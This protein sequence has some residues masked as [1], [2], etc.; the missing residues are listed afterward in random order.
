MRVPTALCS[1]GNKANEGE[2][3]N[4]KPESWQ[5]GFGREKKYKKIS[6]FFFLKIII[7]R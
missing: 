6:S 3:I 1:C 2:A 5:G 4:D 7:L